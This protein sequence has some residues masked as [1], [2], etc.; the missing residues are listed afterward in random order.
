VHSSP[1]RTGR[2]GGATCNDVGAAPTWKECASHSGD[3]T[4]TTTSGAVFGFVLTLLS[5]RLIW[6]AAKR[7]TVADY[8]HWQP[9]GSG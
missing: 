6:P 3:E 9:P 4:R 5:L 1:L 7:R 2:Y 8:L